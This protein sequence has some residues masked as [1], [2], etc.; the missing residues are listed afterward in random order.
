[1]AFDGLCP[2]LVIVDH[3]R[4]SKNE[5]RTD[6]LLVPRTFYLYMP[7]LFSTILSFRVFIVDNY[8]IV[9]GETMTIVI[10][11]HTGRSANCIRH[12]LIR[13]VLTFSDFLFFWQYKKQAAIKCFNVDIF[14]HP[15]YRGRNH[16]PLLIFKWH[17][18]F[19]IK[20]KNINKTILF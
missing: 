13:K 19:L 6:V 9:V 5:P 12:S 7:S 3:R 16:Y 11:Y 20:K 4:A 2:W 10:I 15:Y 18:M 17:H 14:C 8:L 1:M